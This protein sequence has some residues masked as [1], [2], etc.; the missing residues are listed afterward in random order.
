M[1]ASRQGGTSTSTVVVQ[2]VLGVG[3]SAL[4]VILTADYV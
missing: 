3:A 2:V 4:L 1:L